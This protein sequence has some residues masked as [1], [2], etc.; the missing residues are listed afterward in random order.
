MS[1]PNWDLFSMATFLQPGTRIMR[2]VP[3]LAALLL[4]H[5]A[6]AY[7]THCRRVLARYK[8]SVLQ[9]IAQSLPL[10]FNQDDDDEPATQHLAH[11]TRMAEAAQRKLLEIIETQFVSLLQRGDGFKITPF[12]YLKHLDIGVFEVCDWNGKSN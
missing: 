5:H 10:N 12:A 6:C 2:R 1:L 7:D 9:E 8:P 3:L 4:T 11:L